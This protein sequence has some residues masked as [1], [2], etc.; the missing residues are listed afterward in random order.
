MVTI[1]LHGFLVVQP[2]HVT[3]TPYSNYFDL[4]QR[5]DEAHGKR[6]RDVCCL[7]I[8]HWLSKGRFSFNDEVSVHVAVTLRYVVREC[9]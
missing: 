1:V 2:S 7:T 8:Y 5:D 9:M 4:I 6:D 3:N